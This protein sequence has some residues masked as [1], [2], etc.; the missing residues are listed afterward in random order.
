MPT[1]LY[2]LRSEPPHSSQVVSAGS[3]NFCTR[4]ISWPQ[5]LQRYW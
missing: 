5:L 2:T 1:A 4:S 3:L